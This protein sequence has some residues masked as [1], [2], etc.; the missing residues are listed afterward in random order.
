MTTA[1]LTTY[2]DSGYATSQ[3]VFKE[4][5]TIYADGYLTESAAT[6]NTNVLLEVYND[7][8]VK[9]GSSVINDTYSFSTAAVRLVTIHG[10]TI[11]FA[12]PSTEGS[13]Y[14]KLTISG[15]GVETYY[16]YV[17]FQVRK[18]Q[19]Y[20]QSAN[21]YLATSSTIS[22]EIEKGNLVGFDGVLS[23]PPCTLDIVGSIYTADNVLVEADI[24]SF[25][26]TYG[27]ASYTDY[28]AALNGGTKPTWD[29]TGHDA[30]S[31]FLLIAFSGTG[32]TSSNER[33][34]FHIQEA[35][36]TISSPAISAAS[37]TQDEQAT[38]TATFTNATRAWVTIIDADGLVEH[39]KDMT[40]AAGAGTCT[41][42]GRYL[43]PAVYAAG[44]IEIH[45]VDSTGAIAAL[46]ETLELEVTASA[47]ALLIRVAEALQLLI[48]TDSRFSDIEDEDIIIA[49]HANE[50][51]K[52][53]GQKS[54]VLIPLRQVSQ[55]STCSLD[56]NKLVIWAVSVVYDSRTDRED[57]QPLEDIEEMMANLKQL[58][59]EQDD[60]P[61]ERLS[62]IAQSIHA[63]SM[64]D[65]NMNKRGGTVLVGYTEI[66]V[67]VL[68][69]E[70]GEPQ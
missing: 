34:F 61:D 14:L 35:Q 20:T 42:P 31:Y 37:I 13:Y 36:P 4:G 21:P 60:D 59:R 43:T 48:R 53:M 46:D 27:G 68:T 66:I 16:V 12:C 45:A 58:I 64:G 44:Q 11:S 57:Y 55:E 26:H 24:F 62:G 8:G 41:I 67:T 15:T 28:L 7:A 6:I 50:A 10:L 19:I 56:E 47:S 69:D 54:I 18:V 2:A 63:T 33:V 39:S 17:R 38:I 52:A 22:A 3:S 23:V 1:T 29:T 25:N 30:G 49:A 32:F 51:G 5:D 65:E 70:N 40:I 9:Q